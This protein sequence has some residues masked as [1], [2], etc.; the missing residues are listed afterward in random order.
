MEGVVEVLVEAMAQHHDVELVLLVALG[1]HLDVLVTQVAVQEPVSEHHLGVYPGP[2]LGN[3]SGVQSH[4]LYFV[5]FVEVGAL[6]VLG[7]QNAL[8]A[9]L[10]VY[11]GDAEAGVAL[12]LDAGVGCVGYL[13]LEIELLGEFYI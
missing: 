3:F 10:G 7:D 11:F 9:V 8:G 1:P 12:E 6:H 13:P 2:L 5:C 4:L